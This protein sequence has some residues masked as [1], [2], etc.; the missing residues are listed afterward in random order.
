MTYFA[1]I[2]TTDNHTFRVSRDTLNLIPYF[3]SR[4]GSDWEKDSDKKDG[5]QVECFSESFANLLRLIEYGADTVSDLSDSKKVMLFQD[6]NYLGLKRE[7]MSDI[8]L[9]GPPTKSIIHPLNG[10]GS[11]FDW[12]RV[13]TVEFILPKKHCFTD[14]YLSIDHGK[15]S[16]S[17]FDYNLKIIIEIDKNI[18]HELSYEDFV[19][20]NP[21][22]M[23]L[24]TT[25]TII[26]LVSN[27][28]LLKTIETTSNTSI[29]ITI[30]DFLAGTIKLHGLSKEIIDYTQ[31]VAG[32][33]D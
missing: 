32:L 13:R 15:G 8:T 30:N 27:N 16:F 19:I 2:V 29:I 28:N 3:K 33:L 14:L 4:L 10:T 9:Y 17:L 26:P 5:I 11:R 7:L 25:K 1:K 21:A 22:L 24:K 20:S 12:D 18:K 23:T 6:A 31:Y